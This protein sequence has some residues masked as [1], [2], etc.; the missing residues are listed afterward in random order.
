PLRVT[1]N[2]KAASFK[3]IAYSA[4][5]SARLALSDFEPAIADF[6]AAINLG[7]GNGWNHLQRARAFEAK[8]E[9]ESAQAD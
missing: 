1:P 4:R 8:G 7:S 6:T 2:Y 5:G 9:H 3:S